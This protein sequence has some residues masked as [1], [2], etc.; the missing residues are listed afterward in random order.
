MAESVCRAGAI[1]RAT[2]TVSW[3]AAML[4]IASAAAGGQEA[5]TRLDGR[6]GP[7]SLDQVE[8]WTGPD[9]ARRAAEFGPIDDGS[10]PSGPPLVLWMRASI[11]VASAMAADWVLEARS[12]TADDVRAYVA[13]RDGGGAIELRELPRLTFG[14]RQ[15]FQLA[16]TGVDRGIILV[17]VVDVVDSTREPPLIWPPQAYADSLRSEWLWLGAF[18]GGLLVMVAYNLGL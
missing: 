5:T 3:S 7:F 2:T 17:R 13:V 4:L 18:Y 1:A 14:P 10:Q 9:D 6:G 11:E 15:T 12:I 16:L 8:V